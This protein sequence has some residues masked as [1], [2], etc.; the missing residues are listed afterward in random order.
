M[1]RTISPAMEKALRKAPEPGSC[2]IKDADL[3]YAEYQEWL[4]GIRVILARID[5]EK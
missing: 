5:G 2:P 4:S 3:F 1:T